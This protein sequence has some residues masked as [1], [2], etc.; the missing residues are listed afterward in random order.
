[1]KKKFQI[2]ILITPDNNDTHVL[3]NQRFYDIING[4]KDNLIM[5]FDNDNIFAKI[6]ITSDKISS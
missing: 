5:M 4:I 1:V 6:E 2:N 3:L